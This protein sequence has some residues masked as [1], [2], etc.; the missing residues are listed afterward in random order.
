MVLSRVPH[1]IKDAN[2][3]LGGIRDVIQ[4][5]YPQ[6][7]PECH[8]LDSFHVSLCWRSDETE[9]ILCD[10]KVGEVRLS[11]I[12]H[13]GAYLPVSYNPF[14]MYLVES[15]LKVCHQSS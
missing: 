2:Q 14:L 1:G 7:L 12:P 4:G 8:I 11:K 13:S 6:T 9:M 5:L 15:S 10:L 3:H